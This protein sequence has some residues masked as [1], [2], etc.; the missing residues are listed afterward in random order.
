MLKKIN[1][2]KEGMK[3]ILNI[4]KLILRIAYKGLVYDN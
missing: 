3:A 1:I 4:I 2:F